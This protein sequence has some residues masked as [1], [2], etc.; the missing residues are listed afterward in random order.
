MT[1]IEEEPKS[2]IEWDIVQKWI[3]NNWFGTDPMVSDDELA[4]MAI[5]IAGEIDKFVQGK[6]KSLFDDLEK[7]IEEADS[8]EGRMSF[9]ID[10]W[11]HIKHKHL[12]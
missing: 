6:L 5:S 3:E 1:K 10:D 2:H 9:S 8:I 7:N 4:G 11:E 12:G